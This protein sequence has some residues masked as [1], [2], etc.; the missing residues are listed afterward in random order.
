MSDSADDGR[1]NFDYVDE[2]RAKGR[3]GD[4]VM[5]CW[6]HTEMY[7]GLLTYHE[8]F[9]KDSDVSLD[10]SWDLIQAIPFD[11]RLRILFL[12]GTFTK[13]EYDKIRK[14]QKR[15]NK[16]LFHLF[17]DNSLVF[18]QRETIMDEAIEAGT[19]AE[20]AYHEVVELGRLP[21]T[22]STN[23]EWPTD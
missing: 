19:S 6:G 5:I 1:Y 10:A 12:K 21:Q 18:G 17:G 20:Y 14:F 13:D 22:V 16:E 23:D 9:A 15:R 11:K 8:I 3:F 2:L 4:V 7:V